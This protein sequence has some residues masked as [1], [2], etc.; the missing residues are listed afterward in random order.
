MELWKNEYLSLGEAHDLGITVNPNLF[1]RDMSVY[2]V[3]RY[4]LGYH[5]ALSDYE[6]ADGSVSFTVTNYG[7]APPLNFNYFALVTDEG[8]REIEEYNKTLLLSGKSVR[9]T[10]PCSSEPLG[11]KLATQKNRAQTVRFAN[12]TRYENG[13]QYFK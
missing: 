10:V 11:V 6:Y 9:Y 1:D 8:E 12:D 7:F 3:I 2:D 13:V 4:H 5:L